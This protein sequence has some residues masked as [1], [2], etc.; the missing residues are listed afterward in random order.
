MHSIGVVVPVLI[1]TDKHLAMTMKCLELARRNTKLPFQLI[2]VES[3]SQYLTDEADIHIFE[4]IATTPE[5]GH[6]LGF[7]VASRNDYVVLLTNDTYMTE[8]WLESLLECFQIPDCGLSTL[9]TER[10]G[11]VKKEFIDE[12][13]WFDVA[14]IKSEVFKRCGY[15]DER[16][17]G[18]WPDTDLLL[19]AYKEGWK[20][21]RNFNCIVTAPQGEAH[22]TVYMNPKHQENYLMGQKL[23]YEKHKDCGL[24]IFDRLK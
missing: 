20:M 6:N 18:S 3:G 9:G 4:R 7:M 11:H 15:Y 22:A 10:F 8:G 19:R 21:Y 14:M 16:Y 24:E 13:N 5:I 23:F 2:I 17:N 1:R 12:G